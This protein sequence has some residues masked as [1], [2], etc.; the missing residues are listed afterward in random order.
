MS[1]KYVL[2]RALGGLNDQLNQ[3]DLCQRYAKRTGRDVIVDISFYGM[4]P[5]FSRLFEQEDGFDVKFLCVSEFGE[6]YLNSLSAHPKS[7]EGNLFGYEI[8]FKQPL[9][10]ENGKPFP[11][12]KGAEVIESLRLNRD[13][14]G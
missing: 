7:T 1:E 5:H 10:Q 11:V 2:C 3:I 8:E 9:S 13:T 4:W 14:D 6:A 12:V